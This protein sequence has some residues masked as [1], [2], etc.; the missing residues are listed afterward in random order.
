MFTALYFIIILVDLFE[1]ESPNADRD[2]PED[3][4]FA[5]NREPL[6]PALRKW[7]A[8]RRDPRQRPNHINEKRTLLN[9]VPCFGRRTIQDRRDIHYHATPDAHCRILSSIVQPLAHCE[10][11]SLDPQ[12]TLVGLACA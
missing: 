5:L 10:F 3:E 6:A 7:G 9:L 2:K 12:R 1:T 11:F 4:R 8:C